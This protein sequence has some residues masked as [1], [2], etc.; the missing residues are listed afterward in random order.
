MI[1][2]FY[3]IEV[4]TSTNKLKRLLVN[5]KSV[6]FL[7]TLVVVFSHRKIGIKVSRHVANEQ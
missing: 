4:F 7:Y 5:L 1:F 3:P 6:V 2:L